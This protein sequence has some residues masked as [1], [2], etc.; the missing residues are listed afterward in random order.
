MSAEY[1]AEDT[2]ALHDLASE[3][4]ESEQRTEV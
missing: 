3:A 1:N 2:Q 4:S